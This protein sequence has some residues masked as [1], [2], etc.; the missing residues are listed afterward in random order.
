MIASKILIA[1]D[2]PVWRKGVISI[3]LGTQEF[4]IV[5]EAPNGKRLL[6]MLSSVEPDIILL[7]LEMPEMNGYEVL[8]KLKFHKSAV[9]CIA[10]S[11]NY[12]QSLVQQVIDE[13]ACA[14]ISKKAE[15][16]EILGTVRCVIENGSCFDITLKTG[17]E[18]T[19]TRIPENAVVFSKRE[20]EI[21]QLLFE[22]LNSEQIGKKLFIS[23]R[24]VEDYRQQM[25]SKAQVHNVAALLSYSLKENV[26]SANTNRFK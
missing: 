5:G 15:P 8:K 12:E 16:A 26:L 20:K 11:L 19:R 18:H 24:T 4:K 14:Y 7:N 17:N 3:L 25:M 21:L 10:V 13:G 1:D 23:R 22:G 9:K 6:E 2:H